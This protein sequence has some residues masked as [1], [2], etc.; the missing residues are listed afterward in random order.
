MTIKNV[1]TGRNNINKTVSVSTINDNTNRTNVLCNSNLI[2]NNSRSNNLESKLTKTDDDNVSI[3]TNTNKNTNIFRYKFSDNVMSL[4]NKFSL[5]HK[6]DERILF[7]EEWKKWVEENKLIIIEETNRLK[8]LNYEG[9][10][11]D[12]MFK[13]VRYYYRKK[14]TGKKELEHESEP[15]KRKTYISLNKNILDLMDEHIVNN[16][17]NDD[18]TQY[19]G[20]IDFCKKNIT[21]LRE[22]ANI[23]KHEIKNNELIMNKF[24]KTYKN[25]YY[26]INTKNTKNTKNMKNT[27]NTN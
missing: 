26:N 3:N 6:D 13:S 12:K 1:F 17:N 10:V 21:E 24:K 14:D 15:E 25:R 22:E 5:D 7:K 2:K 19:N 8:R 27:K 23:L 20:F 11:L 16:M 18:Y 9:D 4:L